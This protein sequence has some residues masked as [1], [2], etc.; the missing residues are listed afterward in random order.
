MLSPDASRFLAAGSSLSCLVVPAFLLE[1]SADNI[2]I[3]CECREAER[4]DR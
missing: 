4:T 3:S 2:S 1:C